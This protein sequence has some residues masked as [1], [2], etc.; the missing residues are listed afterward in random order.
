MHIKAIILCV[1]LAIAHP[2][3]A[4]LWAADGV[5]ALDAG[6]ASAARA[7]WAPLAEKGDVLAQYNL[8]VLMLTGQGGAQDM[9]GA[10]GLLD[11]AARQDHLPAQHML[12]A[13]AAEQGD[14]QGA[15]RWYH[16]LATAG[17]AAA[18]AAFASLLERGLGGVVD[19][20]SAVDWYRAAAAQDHL[21][22]QFA[23][24][25][26]LSERGDMAEAADWF[27]AAAAQG[28]ARAMHNLAG[29]LARGA[30]RAKDEAAARDWYLRAALSGHAPAM[31][32]LALM[33]ARGRG[34]AQ[35]F[36]F[37][38]AWALNA[39]ALDEDSAADLVEALR[40][41]MPAEAIEAAAALASDC[42]SAAVICD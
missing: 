2:A 16:S 15:R 39:E 22:A 18:Q 27:K 40:D 6:D 30:G 14:W 13:L 5:A 1:S 41:V 21:P 8:A 11:A 3:L 12:A 42:A 23:L 35:S 4:Q 32:N 33:Q 28:D 19:V 7:I 9:A 10:L 31:R 38:L 17:E 25:V 29:L 20:D 34:G 36:R 26:I 37:A 24:A